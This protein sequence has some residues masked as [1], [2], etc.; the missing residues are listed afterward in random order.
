MKAVRAS[1]VAAQTVRFEEFDL[2]DM[3]SRSEVLVKTDRT[4]VSAGTELAN[5][6]GLDP[7]T[8]IPGRWCA[9][10]WLPGYGGVGRVVAVGPDV[11]H[12]QPGDRVYGIFHHAS[13]VLVDTASKLCVPVPEQLDS[14]TAVM[15]RMCGVAI[16]GY[17][18][19]RGLALGDMVVMIGL[20]LVGN[21]A[22]QFFLRAGQRVVGLDMSE[23]RRALAQQVGYHEV[24]DPSALSEDD[25][26]ARVQELNGGAR[27]PV[28]V[29]AVGESK[30]VEQAVLRV[31]NNGQVIMLGTPRAA[32]EA[33]CTVMLKYAHFH[34]VEIIGALEWLIPLLKRQAGQGVSTE[35]NSELIFKM[36]CDGA[37]QVKPLCSHVLKPTELNA[38]YQGL[39]HQKDVYMGVVLDWENNPPPPV[40]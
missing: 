10:P 15:S 11:H 4:I 23:R 7:D 29:D 6:T 37:L 39:L 17:R 2:P 36:L 40:G 33:D 31:A 24:L 1:I 9:Y 34:G 35:L 19:T 21:L 27:P 16:T 26:W 12:L 30:I 18:R 8:R 22:G 38:A 20:G 14:T 25:L 32:Y 28:I 13:Y 5:Y 3:P